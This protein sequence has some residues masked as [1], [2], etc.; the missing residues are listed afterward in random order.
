MRMIIQFENG[1]RE[2]AIVL[3]VGQERMRISIGSSPDTEELCRI[4]GAW[5]LEGR[6]TIEIEALIPIPGTVF[7]EFRAK[8]MA[9]GQA[10]GLD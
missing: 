7:P 8:A 4:D 3:A 5:F 2:E 1:E 6:G 9:A 10:Y